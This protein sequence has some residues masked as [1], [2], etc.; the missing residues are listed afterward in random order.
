MLE[1]KKQIRKELLEKGKKKGVLTFKEIADAFAEV[2]VTQ[3]EVELL[4]DR[5]EKEGIEV[6]EDMEKELE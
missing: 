5:I 2:E 4:Y 6:V 1:K 3:E